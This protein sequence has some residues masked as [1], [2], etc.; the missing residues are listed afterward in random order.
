V[1][2]KAYAKVNIFLKIT[3]SRGNYHTLRSRF[4]RVDQLYDTITFIKKESKENI[5]NSFIVESNID[6]P[7]KNTITSAYELLCEKSDLVEKFFRDYKVTLDKKIPT[8]AG[9]GGGSSDSAAF[10]NLCNEVCELNLSTDEI[11]KIGA[12]IGADVPFFV[13]NY[14]SA[15]VEGI[16]EVVTPF[17]EDPPKLKLFT[18][19]IHCDTVKV[20]KTFR[21]EFFHIADQNSGAKWLETNSTTLLKEYDIESLNDL[22]PA[23]LKAYPELK[24]FVKPGYFFSGSG[25]TFFKFVV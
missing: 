4:V 24:K 18:P 22:F 17:E 12:K 15:N 1:K 10:L 19:Q 5:Q 3:G 11:A 25:S 8:G 23:A 16:G 13:Y 6:L 14:K 21:K 2:I 9:L 7:E 20:Y